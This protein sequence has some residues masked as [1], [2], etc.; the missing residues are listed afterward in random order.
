[1]SDSC[2][3][4]TSTRQVWD[5]QATED[6]G[7]VAVGQRGKPEII[8]RGATHSKESHEEKIMNRRK[9]RSRKEIKKEKDL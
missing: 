4:G 1:M 9:I 8:P 3:G 6:T 5:N 2:S 7:Q